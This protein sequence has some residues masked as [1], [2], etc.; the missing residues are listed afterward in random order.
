MQIVDRA[1]GLFSGVKYQKCNNQSHNGAAA[2]GAGKG[3]SRWPMAR[4]A[5]N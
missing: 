2:R 1:A 4:G 3:A 5:T